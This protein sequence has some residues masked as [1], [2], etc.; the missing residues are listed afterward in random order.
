MVLFCPN[1]RIQT[2][3]NHQ[4]CSSC[5]QK[6][7]RQGWAE[8][9]WLGKKINDKYKI[10]ETLGSGGFGSVFRAKQYQGEQ[11][12]GDVVLKFLHR[13]LAERNSYRRRFIREAQAARSLKSPHIVRIFDLDYDKKG[14]PFMVME[15]LE[16]TTLAERLKEE[17]FDIKRCLRLAKQVVSAMSECH[18]AGIL[19][20]DLKP[21]NI[22][23]SEV[24]G[25][26]FARIIDFGNARIIDEELSHTLI[27]TPRYMP[28]EQREGRIEDERVDI[29]ALG[30]ILYEVLI[31]KSPFDGGD[32]KEAKT[33]KAF[34][35]EAPQQLSGLLYLMVQNESAQ[36][37]HSMDSILERLKA[38]E[39]SIVSNSFYRGSR[40]L[41]DR[42]KTS[43]KMSTD[44]GAQS[45]EFISKQAQKKF[46]LLGV[47]LAIFSLFLIFAF[48]GISSIFKGRKIS[49]KPMLSTDRTVDASKQEKDRRRDSLQAYDS[50][51][52]TKTIQD[53]MLDNVRAIRHSTPHKNAP[54]KKA[55]KQGQKKTFKKAKA[56]IS[57]PMSHPT[58]IV[59]KKEEKKGWGPDP[60]EDL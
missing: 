18:H 11:E 16:G 26:D 7:P 5:G 14:T 24:S 12:I 38:I 23:V 40:D 48:V 31:G 29:F 13:E 59:P 15:A 6:K 1:C 2:Q 60:S 42:T 34:W 43:T 10:V 57:T 27:G 25:Q 19:H 56:L 3:E 30:I 36:R 47:G 32:N 54:R 37:P 45:E 55:K 49:S 44:R 28:P 22:M 4:I 8:D 41:D 58:Q 50:G 20:R 46:P 17:T 51:V 52:D 21:S 35:P 33:L 9:E 53:M 39:D